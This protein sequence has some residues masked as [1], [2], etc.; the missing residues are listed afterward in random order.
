MFDSIS[1]GVEGAANLFRLPF[2]GSIYWAGSGD[3][4]CSSMVPKLQVVV[5]HGFNLR[6]ENFCGSD[7]HMSSGPARARAKSLLG[8]RL[9][10]H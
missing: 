8:R 10:W 1:A 3:T 6:Q 2:K 7:L 5:A 9:H 4:T